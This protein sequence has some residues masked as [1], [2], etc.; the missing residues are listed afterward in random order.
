MTAEGQ[1]V[2]YEL[3]T[4]DPRAAEAFYGR[5]AGWDLVDSGHPAMRYTLACVGAHRIAGIMEIPEAVRAH[6]GG[7]AWI[8]YVAVAD[9]DAKAQEVERLGGLVARAPEDIPGIGRFA[10]VCDPQGAKF[11]L[12]RGN[13]TPP[14]RPAPMTPGTFGW[15][16]LYATDWPAAFAFYAALFGWRKGE[17]IAMGPMGTYQLFHAGPETGVATGGMMNLPTPPAP[18][19]LYYIGVAEILAATDRLTAA[20][21][22]VIN[23]P[24]EV[25]GGMWVVQAADPQG[26]N[27]ALVGPRAGA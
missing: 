8:G 3:M 1:F 11:V 18:C 6:G 26:A 27:F 23:G 19:W 12:F 22:A 13:G 5:V 20:G 17:A 2:W 4:T 15:H 7:P 14:P 10:V 9:V 16:E 25:P 24:M 21:G